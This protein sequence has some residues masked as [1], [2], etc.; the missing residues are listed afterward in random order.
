MN[1]GLL[2]RS[3]TPQSLYDTPINRFVAGFI[4]SPSMNFI[5]VHLDGSGPK[6]QAGRSG[7]LGRSLCLRAIAKAA[8]PHE[9]KTIV[10]ASGRSTRHRPGGSP[11]SPPSVPGLT[12]SSTSATRSCS[13]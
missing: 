4:G 13:T 12:W 11:A 5:E 3:G 10:V 8:T 1:E 6:R 2:H 9:G 7:R